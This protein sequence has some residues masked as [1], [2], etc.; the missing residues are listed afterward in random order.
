VAANTTH[1]GQVDEGNIR[2]LLAL[3][4][5]MK[6]PL[7]K[8]SRTAELARMT[9]D[10]TKIEDIEFVSDMGIDLIESYILSL[11]MQLAGDAM[12]LES[13]SLSA[14]LHDV[15]HTLQK[16]DT[17]TSFDIE[18]H[19]AGKY[20]P[21]MAHPKGLQTALL[22]IG[23]VLMNT[24]SE[25]EGKERAILTL[26]A[27]RT[28]RGIAAGIFTN[29]D[30]LDAKT[31]ARARKLYGS[32][33]QPLPQLTFESGAGIFIADS[34]LQSMESHLRVSHYKKLT[35]LA[36]TFLPSQQLSLV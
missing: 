14:T 13:V 9:K 26:A 22:N 28:Q 30:G 20:G 33:A 3:A 5:C 24:H 10:F 25:R 18:L 15:A 1:I 4:E 27:R 17:S 12:P 16:M 11:K 31:F 23:K 35:G 36:A 34:L 19:I 29:I 6:T 2:L 32:A 8:A 7:L 21:I